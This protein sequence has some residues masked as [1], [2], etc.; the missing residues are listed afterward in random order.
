MEDESHGSTQEYTEELRDPVT[1]MVM[2]VRARP[3]TKP[4]AIT[5]VAEQLVRHPETLRN[6][7]RQAK[8]EIDGGLRPATTTSDA[9]RLAEL[10]REHRELRR[11]NR[12]FKTASGFFAAELDRPISRWWLTSTPIA[13]T[14]SS[15][16]QVGIEPSARSLVAW[17]VGASTPLS[18][19]PN[20]VAAL[21]RILTL[22]QLRCKTCWRAPASDP[23]CRLR[24]AAEASTTPAIRSRSPWPSTTSSSSQ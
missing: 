17:A 8:A 12:I 10:G 2:E 18:T 15:E 21:T 3:D 11:A 13:T 23:G 5:R 24:D 7:V 9:R 1:R 22:A 16:R 14:W 4:G 19:P 6:W 20:G